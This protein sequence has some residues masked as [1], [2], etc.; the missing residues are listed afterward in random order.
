M[1]GIALAGSNGDGG[2]PDLLSENAKR[3]LRFFRDRR[4]GQGV[5]ELP[6]DMI[7]AF[8]GDAQAC[9]AALDELFALNLIDKPEWR[10]RA[11]PVPHRVLASALTLE[12]ER[13]IAS[14]DLA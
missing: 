4:S 14:H 3:L 13:F 6:V 11:G 8:D 10:E 9:E 5:Y 1:P 7:A 2:V 12:G